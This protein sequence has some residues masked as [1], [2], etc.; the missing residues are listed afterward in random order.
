LLT[1]AGEVYCK[2]GTWYDGI[3][4][5]EQALVYFLPQGMELAILANSEVAG[6]DP[7]QQV[8]RDIV[9][10]TYLDNLTSQVGNA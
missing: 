4:R 8:L 6:A 9:T 7:S 1:P 5:E 3:G 2:P 10:Q